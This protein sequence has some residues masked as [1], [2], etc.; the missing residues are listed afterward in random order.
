MWLIFNANAFIPFKQFKLEGRL[1]N[2]NEIFSSTNSL[3]ITQKSHLKDKFL[4]NLLW[5]RECGLRQRISRGKCLCFV[6][7][8]I[9]FTLNIFLLFYT[10]GDRPSCFMAQSATSWVWL[11]THLISSFKEP[12]SVPS[13]DPG[14]GKGLNVNWKNLEVQFD[15]MPDEV[16][17]RKEMECVRLSASDRLDMHQSSDFQFHTVILLQISCQICPRMRQIGLLT[18]LKTDQ[19]TQFV[20]SSYLSPFLS[21]LIYFNRL[22]FVGLWKLFLQKTKI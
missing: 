18:G 13:A 2:I 21:A 6:T 11:K 15:V 4:D 8:L 20:F 16:E 17:W 5:F 14:P 12:R 10:S 1:S 9:Y 19:H 22:F 3:T 7:R